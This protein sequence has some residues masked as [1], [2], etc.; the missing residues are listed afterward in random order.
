MLQINYRIILKVLGE[1]RVAQAYV[2]L[3]LKHLKMTFNVVYGPSPHRVVDGV[4]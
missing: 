1:L 3:D 4:G 2:V